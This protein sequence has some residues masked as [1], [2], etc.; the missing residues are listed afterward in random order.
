MRRLRYL[1]DLAEC[2]SRGTGLWKESL[3]RT[4][5]LLKRLGYSGYNFETHTPTYFHKDWVFDAYCDF[6]DYITNDRWYGMLGPTAILNHALKHREFAITKLDAEPWRAG[7]YGTPP[8]YDEIVETTKERRFLSF[9]DDAFGDDLRSF[10]HARFPEAC[11][12]E[13]G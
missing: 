13:Q 4:Y 6:Q 9:D 12:Y 8:T 7:W 10:L 2:K 5:D 11:V 1:E 3:W